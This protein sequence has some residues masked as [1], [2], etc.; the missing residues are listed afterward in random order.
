MDPP[1]PHVI[2][3]EAVGAWGSAQS[4]ITED[5]DTVLVGVQRLARDNPDAGDLDHLADRAG[6][7]L[8]ALPGVGTQGLDA[9]RE[10]FRATLSRTA[11]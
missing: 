11:P 6:A 8:G 2:G 10:P 5:D 9:D 3:G 4:L 1:F 7:G